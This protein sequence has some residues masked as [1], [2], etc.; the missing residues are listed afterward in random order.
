[1]A[2]HK[3]AQGTRM[4]S[5]PNIVLALLQVQMKRMDWNF[6]VVCGCED[7]LVMVLRA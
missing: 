3:C 1:M 4:L 7:V 2:L 5:A 6:Q